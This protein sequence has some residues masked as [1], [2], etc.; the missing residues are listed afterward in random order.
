VDERGAFACDVVV[1]G[2]RI[3][4]TG[5][6]RPLGPYAEIDAS[7]LW[8]LPGGVDVHTHLDMPVGPYH[9]ATDFESGGRDALLGGTTTVIDFA[10]P[11][12]GAGLEPALDVWRARARRTPVDYGLHMSIVGL[13][14]GQL[15]QM[16]RVV[17]AGVTSFKVFTTYPGRMMLD[18][19]DIGRVMQRARDLDALVVVHAED[20]APIQRMVTRAAADGRVEPI[21]HARTRPPRTEVTAV[22]RMIGV[23]ATLDAALHVAH[24]STAGGAEALADARALGLDVTGETCPQYLWLDAALLRRADGARYLCTPPVRTAA[25]RRRLW[26]A[27]REATLDVVATDHCPWLAAD[28][29]GHDAFI[30]VPNGLPG[31]GQRLQL[32]LE[33]VARGWI[34]PGRMVTVWSAGPARRFGLMPR[35]GLVSPGADADL[36]AVAPQASTV[37]APAGEGVAGPYDGMAV[38]GAIRWV[39][40]RGEIVVEEG[41]FRGGPGGGRFIARKGA[42]V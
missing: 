23:A 40:R 21:H 14:E 22:R 28:K 38:R 32:L 3:E 16:E 24:V 36:V 41:R 34:D 10:N 13:A 29:D 7:G 39:M 35:K 6:V 9:T 1:R 5:A 26:R 25:H 19:A 18:D 37:L 31:V 42:Q 33:G 30:T 27:L 20:D 4:A 2:E 17:E 8:L 11:E 15:Q 12:P